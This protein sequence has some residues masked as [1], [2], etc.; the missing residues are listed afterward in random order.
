MPRRFLTDRRWRRIGPLTPGKPGDPGRTGAN[1]R[2]TLEGILWI[3]RTGA[4]WRDV[5]EEF[6][7]WN[8]IYRRFRRWA[9]SGAL[10]RIER[11]FPAIEVAKL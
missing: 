9:L 4:P 3:A 11:R 7:K 1:N 2:L 8:T 10:T 5:P 6:G